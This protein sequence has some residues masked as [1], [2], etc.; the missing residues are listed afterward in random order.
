[1][2]R[3]AAVFTPAFALAFALAFAPVFA[4]QAQEPEAAARVRANC[5]GGVDFH[6]GVS[7]DTV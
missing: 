6:A 2:R 1:M 7:P 5:A 3:R 4:L